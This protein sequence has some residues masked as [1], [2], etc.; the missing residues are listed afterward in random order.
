MIVVSIYVLVNKQDW[1]ALDLALVR[2]L[3]QSHGVYS[4]SVFGMWT[5]IPTLRFGVQLMTSAST[6]G[7]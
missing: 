6:A 1:N 5:T 3:L 4:Y 7:T 2:V